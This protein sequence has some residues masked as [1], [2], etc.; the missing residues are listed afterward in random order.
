[1]NASLYNG[2]EGVKSQSV[3]MDVLSN[4]IANINTVGYKYSSTEFSDIF[5][6]TVTTSSTN[7][8]QSGYSATTSATRLVFEQGSLVATDNNLDVALQGKGFFG[9]TGYDGSVYYTRDG[10]FTQD[11]NGYLVTSSGFYVLGTMNPNFTT[12]TYSDRVSDLMGDMYDTPVTSGYT[13]SSDE[14]FSLTSVDT[15]T[16]ILLP[17]NIYLE[18]TVTENVSWTGY[19]GSGISTVDVT[20]DLD[21]NLAT[22]TKNA[23]DTY[24]VSGIITQADVYSVKS[25]DRVLVTFSDDN[26]VHASYEAY[27]DDNFNFVI[28]DLDL[29]GFDENS[30]TLSAL[31]VVT[32]EEQANTT[33]LESSL[34]NA[35]GSKST[36]VVTLQRVL[37]QIDETITYSATAQIYNSDGEAVGEAVSGIL[38]FNELGSLSSSTLT[39][40]NNP[41]GGV[42]N[43]NFGTPYDENVVGSGFNG[44][45]ISLTSDTNSVSS[46][47]DGLAEGFLN[48]YTVGDDGSI[49]ATFSNGKSVTVA[50]L[51]LYNFINEEGLA[52]VGE[53]IYAATGNSGNAYFYTDAN[54]NIIYTATFAGNYLEQSNVDLS[55]ELSNLI[56]TQRAYEVSAASI[57]TSDEMIQTAIEMKS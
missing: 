42:V 35:D 57:T 9:V 13:V 41:D 10:S 36:V 4:N 20:H 24:S 56:V 34:Y 38:T 43:L 45:Y 44:L 14:D 29:S 47:Q 22:Y 28:D 5:Y 53:N 19:L 25:G 18:P 27:L 50:K 46:T 3:G 33:T 55:T 12:I 40:I 37:P 11:A 17:N 8:A 39:S 52:A 54:G 15:Q 16:A 1:M 30:L 32:E 51:A 26:G 2:V 6:S 21:T 23:D 31:Q 49:I 7:P 48:S